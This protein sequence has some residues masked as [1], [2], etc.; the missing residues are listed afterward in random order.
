[1]YISCICVSSVHKLST[2]LLIDFS[3]VCIVPKYLCL[4]SCTKVGDQDT[5]ALFALL[6]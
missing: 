4:R 5:M 3:C 6:P 2:V 1:M